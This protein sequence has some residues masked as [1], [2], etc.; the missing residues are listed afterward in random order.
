MCGNI[1]LSFFLI[2]CTLDAPDHLSD[3]ANR[4]RRNSISVCQSPGSSGPTDSLA[5]DTSGPATI[6]PSKA[7][8]IRSQVDKFMAADFSNI[9]SSNV[10]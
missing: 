7:V 9:V 5:R 8:S 1:C 2:G 6:Q 4:E 3:P 10:L